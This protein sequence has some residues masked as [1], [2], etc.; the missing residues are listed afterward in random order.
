MKQGMNDMGL[1]E[2][3]YEAV[4]N[5]TD[6]P[7][8]F[9]DDPKNDTPVMKE[10]RK[11]IIKMTSHHANDRPSVDEVALVLK[12]LHVQVNP[13]QPA[14]V[15]EDPSL[16]MLKLVNYKFLE[17]FDESAAPDKSNT[18]FFKA[19]SNLELGSWLK[20]KL[21]TKKSRI[22]L[23]IDECITAP[24]VKDWIN[25]LVDVEHL[26]YPPEI[27][28][29]VQNVTCLTFASDVS[30]ARTVRRLVEAGSDI[31]A[32]DSLGRTARIGGVT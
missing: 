26:N 16:R 11:L 22:Q 3:M 6:M 32:R 4:K 9:D 2:D 19:V 10:I 15:D 5:G 7:E 12:E 17:S 30:D 23:A 28:A 27:V 13:S 25:E 18:T 29:L 24:D 1:G 20:E 14:E 21:T 8:V 31:A